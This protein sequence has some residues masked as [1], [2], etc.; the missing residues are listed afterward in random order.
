M[1]KFDEFLAKTEEERPRGMEIGGSF[2]CQTC[3]EQVEEA[4]WFQPERLL[5]WD[6]SQGHKSYIEGFSL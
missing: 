2:V 6:C 1:S 5:V 4:E 3:Y